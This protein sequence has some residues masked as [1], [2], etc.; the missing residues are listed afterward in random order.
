MR[1]GEV[2]LGNVGRKERRM[3]LFRRIVKKIF[4]S[5]RCMLC[6]WLGDRK[7]WNERHI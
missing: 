1:V 7:G 2:E 6:F 4:K 3:R 5:G